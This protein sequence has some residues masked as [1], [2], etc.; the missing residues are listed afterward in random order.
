MLDNRDQA[1]IL[2]TLWRRHVTCPSEVSYCH[3]FCSTDSCIKDSQFSTM[4]PR[5][6]NFMY[7][8]TLNCMWLLCRGKNCMKL[9]ILKSLCLM[10]YS[11]PTLAAAAVTCGEGCYST[12]ITALAL[13]W[14]GGAERGATLCRYRL[15]AT[16]RILLSW[17]ESWEG[18]CSSG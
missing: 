13:H 6:K 17:E 4:L 3:C 11:C 5:H 18:V 12:P 15:F 10:T 14:T 16:F 2:V 1:G 7:N 8:L 9:E